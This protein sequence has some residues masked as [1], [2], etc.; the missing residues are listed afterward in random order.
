MV[1][2]FKFNLIFEYSGAKFK[3]NSKSYLH[4]PVAFVFVSTLIDTQDD[5]VHVLAAV[6]DPQWLH[7]GPT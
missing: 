4:V 6:L 2:L 7:P 1:F 5:S 3:I